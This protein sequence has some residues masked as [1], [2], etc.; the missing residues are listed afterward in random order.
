MSEFIP[1]ERHEDQELPIPTQWR[2]TLKSIVECFVEGDFQP[3]KK[4]RCILPLSSDDSLNIEKSINAYGD[5]LVALP[6][7]M[8]E[9]SF[10]QATHGGWQVWVYLHTENEM[11]SDLVLFVFVREDEAGFNYEIESVHVP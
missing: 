8:W 7:D 4:F 2:N 11:P 9:P 1:I 10:Y 6:L 5:K 3:N